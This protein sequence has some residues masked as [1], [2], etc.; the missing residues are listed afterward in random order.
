[1][2]NIRLAVKR[3]LL[4]SP[5]IIFI[6]TQG[7]SQVIA[8]PHAYAHNDYWHK[9]PLFDALD[10]GFKYI[11]AD[12]F[13]RKEKL[14][15]AHLF[16]AFKK[17]HTLEDLYLKPLYGRFINNKG[18]IQSAMDTIVLM[19][20][21]KSNAEDTYTVLRKLLKGF[22]PMLSTCENGKVVIRNLTI[23]LTGHRPL[24]LLNMEDN[25]F[26]FADGDLRSVNATRIR[27]NM[28]ATASCKYSS[29]IRW[30]GKG[31]IPSDE[32]ERLNDL[33][34]KAHLSGEKVRLWASPEKEKV[35]VQLRN[36]GVDLINTDKLA[37]L[38]R[39]FI[40]GISSQDTGG[41]F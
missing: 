27:S 19:I 23:I 31:N 36:C 28:Y 22:K 9:R 10:N 30:R 6:I 7:L 17:K 15:V 32:K 25:R 18:H 26:V 29:L 11:E 24:Q 41:E 4:I 13:L 33:V 34:S 1:M 8:L 35:W 38:K 14:L 20:D 3:F 21:I 40:S 12:I 39:F 2:K 5:C 16:P 37:A